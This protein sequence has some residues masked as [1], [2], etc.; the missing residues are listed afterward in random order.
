MDLPLP[1]KYEEIQREAMSAQAPPR[2]P[3]ALAQRLFSARP[4]RAVSLKPELFEGFRFDF[5]KGLNQKFSLTHSVYMG[6]AEARLGPSVSP[7]RIP[8][9]H[10]SPAACPPPPHPRRRCATAQFP[11]AFPRARCR[12]RFRRRS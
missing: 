2:L 9:N 1:I 10:A 12:P 7:S 3:A 5:N 8:P 11:R 4:L 6:N